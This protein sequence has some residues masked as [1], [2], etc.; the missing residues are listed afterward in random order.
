MDSGLHG[1]PH[2][3]VLDLDDTL[4]LE[5][6]YVRSGFRAVDAWLAD[7]RG[8]EGFFDEAWSL[9]EAGV[10]GRIFNETLDSLGLAWDDRLIETLVAVYREHEPDI[11][12][13]PDARRFLEQTASIP[14]RAL[15]TDGPVESQV[16]KVR[17]LGLESVLSPVV[18]TWA[19]GREYGKPHER[20]FRYIEE[21]TGC[22]GRDCMYVADN[23]KK[24]F[25]AP[26]RLGWRTVRV[27]RPGSLH[28]GVESG[29]DVDVEVSS[30]AELGTVLR[31]S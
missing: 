23:P 7:S 13:L 1:F 19:W 10:R 17:A 12:L 4:Y 8:I 11:A 31:A 25:V 28:F 20:G 16:R 26:K 9:F 21:F 6:D 18:Y 30:F 2:C 24:D 14:F 3:L 5:R 15:L 27:R 29:E 22:S